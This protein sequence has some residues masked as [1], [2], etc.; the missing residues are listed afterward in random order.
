MGAY[1]PGDFKIPLNQP[2]V[3]A[4]V[5]KT[6]K[7]ELISNTRL[8]PDYYLDPEDV[9]VQRL[10]ELAVPVMVAGGVEAVIDVEGL[11]ADVFSE[12]DLELVEILAANVS[13]AIRRIHESE[14]Q[15]RNERRLRAL[16]GHAT[17]LAVAKSVDDVANITNQIL[18]DLLGHDRGSLGIVE[19][20]LLHHR[21][22]WNME[23]IEP[24]KM[25]LNGKGLT[26][27][28]VRTGEPQFV[29]D[30]SVND[31]FVTIQPDP[32]NITKSELV[33]P[34]KIEG[35]VVA[36]INL[37]SLFA[38]A[39]SEDDL[40]ILEILAEHIAGAFER[41]QSQRELD[42]VHERHSVEF[43]EGIQ[44]VS[45][46]VRHDLR[47]PL[48]TIMNATYL[49]EKNP[50]TG[51]EMR[52]L[53]MSSVKHANEIMEDWKNQGIDEGLTVSEMDIQALVEEA[54]DTSLIPGDV[55]VSLN[56]ESRILGVDR[57]KVHRVLNN[58]VRNAV[59]A[60]PDG[61]TLMIKGRV[62]GEIYL[63]ELSD[64]GNGISRDGLSKIFTPFYS[65]KPKGMG[66]GLAFS[67]KTVEAHGGSIS[68]ESKV[69]EGTAFTIRFPL[70]ELTR[71]Q[72][73][74]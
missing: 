32:G 74:R 38:N 52:G 44:R 51:D 8:D 6:G 53:V 26:V 20:G 11:E 62:D 34:V 33:V 23:Q 40:S 4:R 10:S 14:T 5:F 72:R 37:E 41:F 39:F 56:V 31:L 19:E 35:K 60:M 7:S 48:Q 30:T 13:S 69:G 42:E 50:E 61:G 47:G 54:L 12:E 67:R 59:E 25:P 29:Q 58:L 57:V 70:E 18:I 63:L 3:V 15:N 65:T 36:V 24:F 66:L 22:L 16:H 43:V 28:A 64:T 27:Q 21:Y 73:A 55:N 71:A 68:V 46:M 9:N 49:M 17:Q 45:S 2:S 1:Q